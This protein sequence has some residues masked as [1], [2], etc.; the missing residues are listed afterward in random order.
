MKKYSYLFF[1]FI[2]FLHFPLISQADWQTVFGGSV[3]Y[4]P[5]KA[6]FGFISVTE[7]KLLNACTENGKIIWQK[8]LNHNSSSLYT[9]T[10]NDFIYI[11][12]EDKMKISL[13]N[14]SGIFLWEKVLPE[15]AYRAPLIGR[16]GRVFISGKK[17]LFC[18]GLQGT[19]KWQINTEIASNNFPLLELNDG[20]LL[21]ILDKTIKN[22]SIACR[23]SPYG[24]ILEEIQFSGK[25]IDT[26]IYSDGIL[27]LFSNGRVGNL[28]VKNNVTI[29]T[30]S[31]SEKTN[32]LN[33]YKII[34]Q[35]NSFCIIYSSKNNTNASLCC[36]NLKTLTKQWQKTLPLLKINKNTICTAYY[37]RYDFYS[38]NYSV[39]YRAIDGKKLWEKTIKMPSN[40]KYCM[41]SPSGYLICTTTNWTVYGY[42]LYQDF[43]YVS[44]TSNLKKSYKNFQVPPADEY[45]TLS[46]IAISF[47]KGDYGT[48]ELVF[49]KFLDAQKKIIF[50]NFYTPNAP[51]DLYLQTEFI[52][53]LEK[54]ETA[55]IAE[56]IA[57]ILTKATDPVII[58]KA[59]QAASKIGYDDEGKMLEAIG[60]LLSSK[61]TSIRDST[62]ISAINATYSICRFMGRPLFYSKGK[63]I[64][65]EIL[66][67]KNKNIEE[68]TIETLEKIILLQM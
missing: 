34:I 7:G 13:Y 64:L 3:L 21:L 15:V 9:I 63:D 38:N 11:I 48:Q 51:K 23:I 26:C 67:F 47:S 5:H 39:S 54:S 59:L 30:W 55:D 12:S 14:P 10:P 37:N 53:A 49:K 17:N 61:K 2:F 62:A 8:K 52:N 6:T 40:I 56:I 41:L 68:Y 35:K 32:N 29:S 65:L 20:S 1:I 22:N 58:Q 27:L 50:K 60:Q 44:N 18:Y 25:I 36:Y 45:P 4:P 42:R 46:N 43:S 16:D 33:P 19:R 24:A 28:S 66:S 31:I 57:T